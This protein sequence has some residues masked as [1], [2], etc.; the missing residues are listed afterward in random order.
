M[1][2]FECFR[3]G[4][5]LINRLILFCAAECGIDFDHCYF[6]ERASVHMSP[7][8]LYSAL[9]SHGRINEALW[10]KLSGAAGFIKNNNCSS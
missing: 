7:L 3:S 4:N 10:T 8:K 5:N 6:I 1:P 9:H 2:R